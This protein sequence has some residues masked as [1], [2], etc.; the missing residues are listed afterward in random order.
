MEPELF[1]SLNTKINL[2][3]NETFHN[4]K[5]HNLA[6]SLMSYIYETVVMFNS[7][8]IYCL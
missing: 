5:G 4:F 8:P 1:E 3:K 6:T 7:F 2:G